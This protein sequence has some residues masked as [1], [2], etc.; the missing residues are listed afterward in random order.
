MIEHSLRLAAIAA[1]AGQFADVGLMLQPASVLLKKAT[2]ASLR[3]CW[4]MISAKLLNW[5]MD[6][7]KTLAPQ[8]TSRLRNCCVF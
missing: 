6:W 3:G 5:Q 8:W 4:R 7:P 2:E 1:A